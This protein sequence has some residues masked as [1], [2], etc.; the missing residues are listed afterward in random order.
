MCLHRYDYCSLLP[1]SRVPERA[2]VEVVT[3]VPI[4][5]PLQQGDNR[6]LNRGRAQTEE[7]GMISVP[8]D[9]LSIPR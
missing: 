6:L 3:S 8:N 5:Q 2:R 7:A 9:D 1:S 4:L